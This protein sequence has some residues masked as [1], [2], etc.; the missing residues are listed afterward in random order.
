MQAYDPGRD[1]SD[2]FVLFKPRLNR[3]AWHFGI[4]YPF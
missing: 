1:Q 3:M 4:G 2:R